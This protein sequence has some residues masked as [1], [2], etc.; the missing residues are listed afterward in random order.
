MCIN[1]VHIQVYIVLSM[2]CTVFIVFN[3]YGLDAIFAKYKLG[4]K[5][6][7]PV[8]FQYYLELLAM[9]SAKA[10]AYL[11]FGIFIFK[12]YL[13]KLDD[14]KSLGNKKVILAW[15]FFAFIFFA[16]VLYGISRVWFNTPYSDAVGMIFYLLINSTFF[17]VAGIVC[18][19][20]DVS[21]IYLYIAIFNCIPVILSF[22]SILLSSFG[23]E[24]IFF[25]AVYHLCWGERF[26][27]AYLDVANAVLLVA[28]R[29]IL[30]A[31]QRAYDTLWNNSE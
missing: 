25:R 22:A 19:R 4:L 27:L 29:Y 6:P 21:Y 11:G 15:V 14:S 7:I 1:R 24:N 9:W 30:E 10:L 23:V 20:C 2:Y 3:I 26:G 31:E 18:R 17:P 12:T 16:V 13:K 28:A 5:N 8:S